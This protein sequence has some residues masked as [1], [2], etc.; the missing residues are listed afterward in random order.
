[1][2]TTVL[3]KIKYHG[4]VVYE[5]GSKGYAPYFLNEI[6]KRI[7]KKL[8]TNIVVVGEA[9]I[10]KSYLAMDIC[11][12]IM[13]LDKKGE[14]RFKLNQVVF[15]HKQ[16]MDLILNLPMGYPIVFDEPSYSLSKRTWFQEVQRA[17][18]MTIESRARIGNTHLL[19]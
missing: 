5:D 12:M 16:Y 7:N 8:A 3:N 9:G 6:M 15:R 10:G 13:G 11:R 14:D 2:A 17:L 1:M 19:S 4:Y 18:V